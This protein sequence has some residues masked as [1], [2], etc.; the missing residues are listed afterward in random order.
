MGLYG[1]YHI[2]AAAAATFFTC[3]VIIKSR[4]TDHPQNLLIPR[5]AT[6]AFNNLWHKYPA[7]SACHF[8]Y[9]L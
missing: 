4:M 9:H 5:H 3:L 1:S 2:P 8:P 6:T 7:E